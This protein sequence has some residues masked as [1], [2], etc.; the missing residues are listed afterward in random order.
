ML[1]I[2]KQIPFIKKIFGTTIL[3]TGA[4]G[5][6][7]SYLVYFFYFLNQLYNAEIKLILMVRNNSKVR[8]VFEDLAENKLVKFYFDDINAPVLVEDNVD[9]IIHAA[10]LANPS[11]YATN[12][13]EVAMPNV[14]GTYYLL[15]LAR[16][17]NIKGFLYFSS[18][19]IYGKPVSIK[20][21]MT[22][23]SYG[24]VD[25]L[26]EQSCYGESKRMGENFCVSFFREYGVPIYIARIAHTY[27]PTMNI[28]TDPR[29][30]ASF[31]K[32]LLAKKNIEMLSDGSAKRPFLYIT[33]AIVA[34]L[35]ILL[36]GKQGE[37]YNVSNVENFL[38]IED[39]AECIV[40][41]R[42]ELH[43]EVIR[44][45]RSVAD[46]Y[47]VDKLN[48]ANC[49]SNEKLKQLGWKSSVTIEEGFRRVYKYLVAKD[50]DK[51]D[52]FR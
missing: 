14:L 8:N 3:I 41:I 6:I 9:Y 38:S 12:P 20:T 46:K 48:K 7:A 30:F 13:V 44:K 42:P 28:E 35:Y 10:S 21:E 31:M 26:M 4:T 25:P 34:F 24:I 33:D 2:V 43:L 40:G 37:A 16:K 36:K 11:Y 19:N 50:K 29:V 51:I 27:A 5:M 52:T 49:P 32:C 39:L 1:E 18:G 47:V 22:E 45:Q 17:K 15:Q 23:E